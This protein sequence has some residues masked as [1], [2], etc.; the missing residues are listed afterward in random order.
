MMIVIMPR[1]RPHIIANKIRENI[2]EQRERER[3]KERER[4]RER[5]QSYLHALHL[6]GDCTFG[7][8]E[9]MYR[10]HLL[11]DCTKF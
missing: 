9:H 7:T 5:E 8:I 6:Q 10:I 1:E 2:L 3:E 4:E 11:V